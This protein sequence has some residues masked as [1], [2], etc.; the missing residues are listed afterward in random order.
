[1]GLLSSKTKIPATG[2]YA[3]PKQ[4]QDL[5]LGLLGQASDT[6]L[7]GGELNTAMFTP[8]PQTADEARAAEMIRAGLAPT[9]ESLRSDVSMLMNPYNEFVIDDLNRQAQGQNSI[10]NQ[11]LSR[12]G[13][14]GS[15]RSIL[16]AS[17]IEQ[18]RLGQIGQFRQGQYNQAVNTALGQLANLRQ[19]DISNLMNLGGFERGLDT[20]T[21]QAPLSALTAGQQALGGFKTE[22]GNFGAPERTVKTGGGLGGAL[23]AIGSIAGTAIGGPIGGAIG[24]A[25]GGGFGGGNGFDLGGALGGALGGYGG[26][27][28]S[29]LGLTGGFDPMTG[30]NW[31][32]GKIGGSGGFF[33]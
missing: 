17:D 23:G 29:S 4:Y 21:R 28:L 13:Q 11:A 25:I 18:Q 14:M 3:L 16:G 15:N 20:A 7:P 2:F 32:S 31:N 8:L 24:G 10:L 26:N 5:Y 33:F 1:M 19:G 30:I 22:F 6:L 9:Q 27:P 12:T